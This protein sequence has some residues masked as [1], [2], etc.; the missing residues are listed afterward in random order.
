M[1]E[2]KIKTSNG[3]FQEYGDYN[4]YGDDAKR[5]ECIRILNGVIRKIEDGYDNG[6]CIDYNGNTVGNWKLS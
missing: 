1:L 3:A 4:R 2:I 6:K 5:E